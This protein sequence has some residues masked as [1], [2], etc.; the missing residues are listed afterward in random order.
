MAS[1][2]GSA[3]TKTVSKD[4]GHVVV[5]GGCGFLG[6]TIIKLLLER[7]A[8]TKLSALDLRPSPDPKDGVDYHFGDITDYVGMQELFAKLKPSVVIH[9]ASPH[10]NANRPEIMY[11]V[12][13]EGTKT[14]V[15][16]AQESG[17][18]AFVYTSSASVL[19]DTKSDLVNADEEYPMVIG[20]AQVEYYTT[21]KVR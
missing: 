8:C 4:L 19:S 18:K 14:M 21:T 11:K 20:D 1:T 9:T 2:S 15:R 7:S 5:T 13:V 12:N 10:F 6:G 17:V 3:R 16:V